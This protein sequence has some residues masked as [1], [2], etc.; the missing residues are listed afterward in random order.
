[1]KTKKL[2]EIIKQTI[3]LDSERV[4]KILEQELPNLDSSVDSYK[5]EFMKAIEEEINSG[6]T[7]EERKQIQKEIMQTDL[8]EIQSTGGTSDIK[9]IRNVLREN[10]T[11]NSLLDEIKSKKDI[12]EIIEKGKNLQTI[13]DLKY[14]DQLKFVNIVNNETPDNAIEIVQQLTGRG[15]D[16][17]LKIL[18]ENSVNNRMTDL[19]SL[20]PK[21]TKLELV[22]I[23][24]S[25]NPNHKDFVLNLVAL[26]NTH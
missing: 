17:N 13:E 16:E 9:T 7:P 4:Q 21:S 24:L 14:E 22:E 10:Y 2:D 15:D 20:N 18:L 8:L 19:V 5:N 26:Q 11:H 6:E 1:L 3:N 23:L 25:E 12:D